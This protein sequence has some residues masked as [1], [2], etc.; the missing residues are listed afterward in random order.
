M[1]SDLIVRFST[2]VKMFDAPTPSKAPLA[3]I[4]VLPPLFRL[5]QHLYE[6]AVKLPCEF[7]MFVPLTIMT[8]V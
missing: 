4:S 6:G 2:K 7:S 5:S 1:L 8:V 3:P